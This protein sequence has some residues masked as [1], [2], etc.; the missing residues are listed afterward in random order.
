M[1]TLCDVLRMFFG[2]SIIYHV[3][4]PGTAEDI[5]IGGETPLP[6]GSRLGVAGINFADTG[7]AINQGFPTGFLSIFV[8]FK[9]FGSGPNL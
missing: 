3:T 5:K 2:I 6:Q 8:D 7:T 1:V 4:Q 9:N